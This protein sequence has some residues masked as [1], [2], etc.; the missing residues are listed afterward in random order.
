MLRQADYD[1]SEVVNRGQDTFGGWYV[2]AAVL[3]LFVM[4]SQVVPVMEI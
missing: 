3:L 2:A 1:M 4:V